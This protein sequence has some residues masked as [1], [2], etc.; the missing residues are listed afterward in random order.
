MRFDGRAA[1]AS[2]GAAAC[3]WCATAL[4]AAAGL[5]GAGACRAEPLH[6]T[7]DSAASGD[8]FLL[9]IESDIARCEIVTV[10]TS[11]PDRSHHGGLL[12]IYIVASMIRENEAGAVGKRETRHHP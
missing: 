1:R 11:R 3:G 7:L 2:A 10:G 12:R 9:E 4:V 5:M 8:L 6:L